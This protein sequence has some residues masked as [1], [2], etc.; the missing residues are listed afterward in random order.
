METDKCRVLWWNVSSSFSFS[1][2]RF[3]LDIVLIFMFRFHI[4]YFRHVTSTDEIKD[5]VIVEESSIAK[6]IRRIVALTGEEAHE[7][8][9]AA[10]EFSKRLDWIEGLQGKEKEAALKPFLG[11]SR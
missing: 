4:A 1:L 3:A 5:F 9:R 8:S 11:V 6:G 7:V 10:A 2:T